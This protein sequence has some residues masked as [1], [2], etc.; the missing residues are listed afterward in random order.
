MRLQLCKQ[1][2]EIACEVLKTATLSWL[3]PNGFVPEVRQSKIDT[4]RAG[5]KNG[6]RTD[7][8]LM[9]S[10]KTRREPDFRWLFGLVL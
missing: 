7:L 8:A 10:S 9:P 1:S 2:A 4:G 6:T 5:L 3:V